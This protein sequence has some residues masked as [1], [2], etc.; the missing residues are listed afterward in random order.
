MT[1]L[2]SWGYHGWGNATG[3]FVRL[4]DA[5]EARGFAPPVFVDTRIRRASAVGFQGAAFAATVGPD[6]HVWLQGLGNEAIRTR[7]GGIRI[8]RPDDAARL[9][10]L[11]GWPTRRRVLFFCS[12]RWPKEDGRVVCHRCVVADLVL[13]HAAREARPWR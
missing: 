12:C 1:T 13:N 8:S 11:G 6:R 9:L 4:V 3:A 7:E 5:V 2:F 10:D